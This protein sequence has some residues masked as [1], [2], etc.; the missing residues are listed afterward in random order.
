[1]RDLQSLTARRLD[2]NADVPEPGLGAALR[3][4]VG[5]GDGR[6]ACE[7]G[8]WNWR[9]NRDRIKIDWKFDRKTAHRKF[10]YKRN[11]FTRSKT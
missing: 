9:M 2:L 5:F 8:A 11:A 3:W 4:N 6:A 7:A 10:G 1:M